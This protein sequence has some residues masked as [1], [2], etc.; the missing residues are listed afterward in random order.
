MGLLDHPDPGGVT[1]EGGC[2]QQG[3]EGNRGAE[4]EPEPEA[5]SSSWSYPALLSLSRIHI[6]R[7]PDS[8]SRR[9]AASGE[10][11]LTLTLIGRVA[12][13]KII[14]DTGTRA[15]LG[16]GRS[17]PFSILVRVAGAGFGR[18]NF[19]AFGPFWRGSVVESPGLFSLGCG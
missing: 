5:S 16:S 17:L 19:D 12:C 11:P 10:P 2:N 14:L 18:L 7:R 9:G 13:C 4:P 15:V 8:T 3:R 1:R 6:R